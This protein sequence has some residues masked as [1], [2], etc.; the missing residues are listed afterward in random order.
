M[1]PISVLLVDDH[2]VAR[3]GLRAMLENESRLQVVGEA[4]DAQQALELVGAL[5][6]RVVLM[7]VKMVPVDGLEATRQIKTKYPTTTV[8]IL[9][10]YDADALIRGAIEAGAAGYLLKD[11]TR[12]L[13]VHTIVAV[14]SGGAM[15]DGKLLRRALVL[16][17]QMSQAPELPASKLDTAADLTSREME[18]LRLVAE[19]WTNRQIADRLCLA[20]VTV[21]KHVQSIIA[22]LHASDRTHAAV[23]AFRMGLLK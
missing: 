23:T 22:K 12:D 15:V 2:T 14:V 19:G 18:I 9:T 3:E 11:V 16:F 5:Q 17:K 1:E 21:K 4:A 10:S 7:D 13:L 8:I 20:E 6:P